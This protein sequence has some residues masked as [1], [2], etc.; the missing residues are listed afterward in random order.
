VFK[1]ADTEDWRK[2]YLDTLKSMDRDERQ[3]R[4]RQH[5]LFRLVEQLCTAAQGRS[6]R[7][8]QQLNRLRESVHREVPP[9]QLAPLG[10]AIIDAARDSAGGAPTP[11]V[12]PATAS[13][14]QIGVMVG[15]SRIRMELVQLLTGIGQDQ[16]VQADAESLRKELEPVLVP[17][18]LPG[19]IGRV[20]DVVTRRVHGLERTRQEL[21]VLLGQLASQLESMQRF[22]DGNASDETQR[23]SSSETLQLQ[24]TGEMAALGQNAAGGEIDSV[25]RN[26]Q[27]RIDAIGRHLQEYQVREEQRAQQ[28]RARTEQM[29]VRMEEMETEARRL[30]ARLTDEQRISM[31]DPLTQ[32]PNRL[33]YEKRIGEEIDRWARF[34]QPAC[35][36]V[37]DIDQFKA[38]NDQYGHRA[39]DKVLTIVADCLAKAIRNSDFLARYGGEEFVMLLPGTTLPDALRLA[40]QVREA[41]TRLGFHFRG[42]PV[43]I[44]VSGGVTALQDG[45]EAD[46]AFDRADGAMYSA[47]QGGRNRV[48][49]A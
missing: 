43:S 45:D 12:A 16:A 46:T 13:V 37:W 14:T 47:K 10:Q 3:S 1:A 21:E 31:R 35:I 33:A 38:I 27:Q 4:D 2:R 23:N 32:I 8:D 42:T 41:I 18:R 15:E 30:K 6:L 5:A 22:V 20:A 24:I 9:E 44:T 29:R 11:A 34:G 26:L 48:V 49:S 19:I 39:G 36:A 17:G 25:H 28:S 40:E 7:L